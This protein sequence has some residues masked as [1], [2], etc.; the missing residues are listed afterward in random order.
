MAR[1]RRL[2]LNLFDGWW[3]LRR[4]FPAALLDELAAAIAAGERGHLVLL[5]Y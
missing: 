4:R 5:C 1:L 3:Q 2:L